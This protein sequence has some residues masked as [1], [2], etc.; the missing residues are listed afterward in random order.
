[1]KSSYIFKQ[2]TVLA[3][4]LGRA[5]LAAITGGSSGMGLEYARLL[6]GCGADLLLVSNQQ[7]QLVQ[8]S[9]DLVEE[10]GVN[11]HSLFLDLSLAGSADSLMDWLD[12]QGL[13]PDI[14]ISNAGMFFFHELDRKT[15]DGRASAMMN[16]HMIVP[17]RLITL[18]GL[19]MKE[20]GIGYILI[21]SSMTARIP[22]PGITVY[23]ATKAFLRSFGCSF[24]YEMK[25]Y[26]I[27]VTTVCPAAV[28]TPLYRMK[29]SLMK[30]GTATG[31]IRPPQ[32]LVRRAL[33]GMFRRRMLLRPAPMNFWLPAL[34]A[35]LPHRLV[36]KI[37]RR[38][39]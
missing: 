36:S 3:A 35:I 12:A 34:I 5:P 11:V 20:R 18:M 16:L 4:K 31:F 28:A 14:F 38:I 6:A 23:S 26:G 7:E 2:I 24:H 9:S 37:W 25:E 27:G 39:R 21:V 30:L 17:A 32:W 33:K 8:V 19:R 29:P 13:E 22:M 10:F 1:M 15:L